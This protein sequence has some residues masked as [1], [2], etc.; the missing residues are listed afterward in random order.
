MIPTQPLHT[1]RIDLCRNLLG[2]R[3]HLPKVTRAQKV[4]V[5]GC[6]LPIA[7]GTVDA[8][9]T[10]IEMG[11]TVINLAPDILG[12]E[13]LVEVLDAEVA[14]AAERVGRIVGPAGGVNADA[15]AVVVALQGV[16]EAEAPDQHD[17]AAHFA[18]RGDPWLGVP[19]ARVG[20]DVVVFD[21][22]AELGVGGVAGAF[23][24]QAHEQ[25]FARVLAEEA[26]DVV[27]EVAEVFFAGE[28]DGEDGVDED[29]RLVGGR[30]GLDPQVEEA[31]TVLH[32]VPR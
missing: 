27:V 31:H 15:A 30:F 5:D 6:L 12:F 11:A 22:L 26:E 7:L 21:D 13:D 1:S 29:E 3:T 20:G 19:R 17:L 16:V 28:G 24:L 14:A 23:A 8:A 25:R 32:L 4:D 10:A 9:P 2:P 18:E